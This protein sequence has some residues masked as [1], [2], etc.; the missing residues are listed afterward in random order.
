MSY[1]FFR[2]IKSIP[3]PDS[4]EYEAFFQNEME[5]I[6]YG[7]TVDGVKMHGWLY[8]HLNHWP[9]Y[10][11]IIDQRNNEIIRGFGNLEFRDN[12]F[13]INEKIT[14]AEEKRKGLLI[15]GTRRFGKTY[16]EASWIARGSLIYEGS[17]NVMCSTNTDDIKVLTA[18]CEA[19]LAGLHPYFKY[20]RLF[21]DWRKEVSFGV[22]NVKGDRIE[23]SKIIVRNLD[24]GRNTEALAGITPKTLVIDEIGKI[25][26][27]IEVFKAAE[28]SF[29][30]MYGWR[31]V[32]ILTGTGGSFV[33]HSDAEK[34]FYEPDANNF[35]SMQWEG[36]A[37]KISIFVPG[38]YREEGKVP[39]KFGKFIEKRG[40]L[41]PEDSELNLLPFL[42]MDESR[43]TAKIDED[44]RQAE[45]S[46][47]PKAA[48]KIR[49]YYP[50]NPADCFLNE[51]INKFPVEA[52]RELL[53]DL[54]NQNSENY[55]TLYRDS[56]DKVKFT[57]DTKLK[58]ITDFPVT[59]ATIK[60][61][62]VVIY[63]PPVENPVPLLYIAGGDP[64][65]QNE[66]D[67]S[68]SLGSIYI[69][70]RLYNPLKGTFQNMMVASYV[71]RPNLIKDWNKNV[72][73]LLELYNATLMIEN[74]GTNFIE[75][76]DGKNKGYYLADG[77]SLLH[78]ITPTTSI[79]GKPKGLPPT[80]AV[81]N[82]CMGLFYDYCNEELTE[83]DSSGKVYKRLGVTRIKD[84]MLLI[85]MLNY[86]TKGG[87]YDR[88]VAFRHALA[89]DSHLQKISPIV[90]Y[91]DEPQDVTPPKRII[92][93]PFKMGGSSP[94]T[95][96]R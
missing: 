89:Y 5:K 17:Q 40:I 25:Q 75:Y 33:T 79:R 61:A 48:L 54:N 14:E 68:P 22:K 10:E 44:I 11:D 64:Y 1:Q 29:N 96:V 24:E 34:M 19:G 2:N 56:E 90:R 38:T 35:I 72:E 41:I 71:A 6:K 3:T 57:F 7:V 91:S 16:F 66:S 28:P 81:I 4:A 49:M 46:Q 74:A 83:V 88:I 86:S 32:P 62:P 8:F 27:I 53:I 94:F 73:M 45:L 20:P 26:K 13:L 47:D 65:N 93:T 55:V 95:Y 43:A 36:V 76:M 60:D 52:I 58:P 23:Y 59:A 70:K 78:E 31:C 80:I 18:T 15:F 21:D 69:Y 50:K 37:K 85:E 30:S 12:E 84:K 42:E 67:N 63:E 87:N 51:E 77:Y 9:N 82:H 39:S 92:R